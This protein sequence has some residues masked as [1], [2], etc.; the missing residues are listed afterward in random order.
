MSSAP[1]PRS[2]WAR[3]LSLYDRQCLTE[4]E[5]NSQLFDHVRKSPADYDAILEALWAHNDEYLCTTFANNFARMVETDRKVIDYSVEVRPLEER[6]GCRVQV[7][8]GYTRAYEPNQLWLA[9]RPYHEGRLFGDAKLSN[10]QF[11]AAVVRLD[12]DLE[13]QFVRWAPGRSE[14][15]RM[16]Q[17]SEATAEPSPPLSTLRGRFLLLYPLFQGHSWS[18]PES[19]AS[20]YLLDAPPKDPSWFATREQFEIESHATYR[21]L[22]EPVG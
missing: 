12:Y 5:L 10:H 4:A 6:I 14:S 2:P 9:G 11:P 7:G 8:G 3:L 22:D 13:L 15:C 18:H 20:A 17:G 16:G 19:V 1:P 21:F